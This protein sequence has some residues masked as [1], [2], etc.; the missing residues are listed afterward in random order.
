MLPEPRVRGEVGLQDVQVVF[1]RT[2]RARN[3]ECSGGWATAAVK[4]TDFY[5]LL[6]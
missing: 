6:N 3:P 5:M 4:R 2:S 1:P